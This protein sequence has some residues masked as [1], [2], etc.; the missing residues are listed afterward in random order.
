MEIKKNEVWKVSSRG[1]SGVLKILEN[2]NTEKDDF[3]DAKIVEGTKTY[4]NRDNKEKGEIVSFRTT[5]TDFIKK[6]E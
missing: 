6:V 1:F 3:F 5:L 4:L 2:I